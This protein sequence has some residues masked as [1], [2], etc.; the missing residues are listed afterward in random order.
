MRK[1]N[2]P[3]ADFRTKEA[4]GKV[5]I[6]D[7]IRKKYVVLTPEEWVRQHVVHYL[8]QHKSYPK[9]LISVERGLNYNQLAKRSDIVVFDRDGKAWMLIECKSPDI[10]IDEQAVQQA[11]VYNKSVKATYVALTNGIRH[12]CFEVGG[13]ART[14]ADFPDFSP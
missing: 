4:N 10:E 7:G 9:S 1:L 14:V 8:V 2:L 11:F 13:S 12:F 6:F 3:A 5:W